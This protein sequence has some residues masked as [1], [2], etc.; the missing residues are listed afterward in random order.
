MARDS[1]DPE[2]TSNVCVDV[3]MNCSLHVGMRWAM[4][5]NVSSSGFTDT[6]TGNP[7]PDWCHAITTR[8]GSKMLCKRGDKKN[9]R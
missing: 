4:S 7:N 9:Q 2:I 3:R 1:S 8:D 6:D 5:A